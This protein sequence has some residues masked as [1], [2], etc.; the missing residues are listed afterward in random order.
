MCTL[1]SVGWVNIQEKTHP[2]KCINKLYRY[3][4]LCRN[5]YQYRDTIL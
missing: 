3:Q 1:L 2:V 4:Y 5:L